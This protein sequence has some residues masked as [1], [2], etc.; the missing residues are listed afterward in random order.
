MK[1][2]NI[3]LSIA[4]LICAIVS[5][6]VNSKAD[7]VI[8]G[9][10]VVTVDK[11]FSITEAVAVKKDKIIFVGANEEAQK[12][13]G[14]NTKTIELN[15]EL[16]LPGLIDSHGH[17]TGYGKALEYIDLVG[18][19]S[20]QEI[21]DLVAE[22]VDD[23]KPGELIRGRGWDQNDWKIKEFP[24]NQELSK[25]SL[26]NPVLLTRIDGH[27]ILANQ[28]ALD[29]AGVDKF[30]AEPKGGK[31][32]R[33]ENGLPTGILIDNAIELITDN[34]PK[35]SR[36]QIR[37]II[38][39]AAKNLNEYG[40]TGIHDAG[41]PITRI[42]DYKYLIDKSEMPVRI[43]AM[44]DDTTVTDVG[45]F[46]NDN[47]IESYGNDHL[48]IKS[49][50]LYADGALGSRGA[51][52]LEPYADDIENSGL[53][54]T[55]SLHMLNVTKAAIKNDYQVCTHAIGDRGIRYV[56][57]IY[58][59]ALNQIPKN[60]HRFRIEHSQIVNL[61]DIPRYAELSVIPSMQ[62]QHAISDMPWV[63]DRIGTDRMAGAYAWRSFID[64]GLIIP[65]G[66]DVP[67][68]IP[69]PLV[70][71]YNA[72]TRQNETG[73][74][75]GGWL[76]EQK[77]TIE[78]VIKGYTIWAA[79]AA[80]QEDILGSIEVGKYADF[81]ILDKDILTIKPNEILDTKP[82]YT[83]VGGKIRYQAEKK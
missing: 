56:L 81:T 69:N 63:K 76:P 78:E 21:L 17:L 11:N 38:K 20:Y 9:G 72:V 79:E 70:G 10:K 36:T 73:F 26:N 51:A 74:P 34:L 47:K 68:E 52:L 22:K 77:M 8:T 27:A 32:L 54:V 83:I 5:C 80:F 16:V 15:G 45:K 71:I 23:A 57:N 44:L 40:I 58:K 29:I 3:F 46:L 13:I 82:I 62:P 41:I 61:D 28:K 39:N 43:N 4:T 42:D 30:T 7:L 31:V 59:D 6:S 24:N 49:I 75:D 50:K 55:D 12:Y 1:K 35:Y 2:F 18:T 67:V 37:N 33:D 65:C 66:S 19:N 14:N 53:I 48:R 64:E 25:I 60:D